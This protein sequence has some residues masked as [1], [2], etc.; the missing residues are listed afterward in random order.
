MHENVPTY[1]DKNSSS[2]EENFEAVQ[3]IEVCSTFAK[4]ALRGETFSIKNEVEFGWNE[5]HILQSFINF[6]QNYFNLRA[7]E[8]KRSCVNMIQ[9]SC[10]RIENI[11]PEDFFIDGVVERM[12]TSILFLFSFPAPIKHQHRKSSER[13]QTFFLRRFYY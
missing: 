6:M 5:Q 12:D 2:S 1:A 3:Y 4:A 8:W 11:F 9:T 10:L 7:L 13:N